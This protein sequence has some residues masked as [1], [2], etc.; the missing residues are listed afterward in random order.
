MNLVRIAG[1]SARYG[2]RHILQNA[3]Y[4]LGRG[5]AAPDR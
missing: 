3:D 5:L 2:A 4:H 1:M